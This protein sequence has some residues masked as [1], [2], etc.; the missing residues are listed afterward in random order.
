MFK[1]VEQRAGT[2]D[3]M[4]DGQIL[5]QV[6]YRLDRYQGIT[7]SGLPVPGLHRI[8]GSVELDSDDLDDARLTLRLESGQMVMVKLVGGAGRIFSEGHGPGVC[9]CC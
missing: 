3:L 5:R 9:L 1:L 4:K 6:R 2:G 8:E 7:E